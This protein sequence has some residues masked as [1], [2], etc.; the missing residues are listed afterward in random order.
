MTKSTEKAVW[1]GT[2]SQLLNAP[3]YALCVLFSWLVVPLFLMA[4]WWLELRCTRYELSTQRLRLR[5]G[6]LNKRTDDLELYRVKDLRLD[7]PLVLRPFGLANLVLETSDRS[8]PL[9]VIR[10]IADAESLM[11]EVRT[12]VEALRIARGIRELDVH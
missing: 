10:G 8:N 9:V 6:V 4:W 12:H 7:E 1:T 3:R 5:S 11:D 2:P